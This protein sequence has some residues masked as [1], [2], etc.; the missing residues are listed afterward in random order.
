MVKN[1]SPQELQALLD[2]GEPLTVIDVREDWELE[3]AALPFAQHIPMNDVPDR[4]DEIPKEGTV[5]FM[6]HH[7]GRSA[8]VANYLESVGYTNLL[9]LDGGI[10]AWTA[11]VDPSL[12]DY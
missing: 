3:Q 4:L 10:A 5:V 6:C 11:D 2:A 8:A 9:N 1:I 7:G 12:K